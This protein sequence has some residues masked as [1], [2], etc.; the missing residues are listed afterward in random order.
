M[1]KEKDALMEFLDACDRAASGDKDAFD[2]IESFELDPDDPA[3]G[4][5]LSPKE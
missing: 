4:I 5:K 1:S 3:A 2:G